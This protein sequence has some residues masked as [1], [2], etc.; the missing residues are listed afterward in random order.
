MLKLKRLEIQ[1][2]LFPAGIPK[3]WCPTLSFFSAAGRFDSS[4]IAQH[5]H[6]LAPHVRGI[7]VPG[8][9]GEGWEM[10]DAQITELLEIVVPIA[11]QLNMK[12]LIGILKVDT[13]SVLRAIDSL[14]RFLSADS[15]VGVTVCAAKGAERTQ[16]D[17]RSGLARVLNLQIRR[18]FTNYLKLLRTKFQL[19]PSLAWRTTMRTSLYLKTLVAKTG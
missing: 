11:L 10:T 2:D 5:M 9:T 17:I 4:R 7:L 14:A 18:R 1:R 19:R 8:S 6:R 13:D 15:V 12:M 16:A 3:L